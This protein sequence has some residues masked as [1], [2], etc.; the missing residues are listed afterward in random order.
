MLDN[1]NHDIS[2]ISDLGDFVTPDCEEVDSN[3][4][5]SVEVKKSS[6]RS[7]LSG[8]NLSGKLISFEGGEGS[9]KTTQISRL[10]SD[11]EKNGYDVLSLREPGGSKIAEEIREVI[12]NKGNLEMTAR[13]E[14]LCFAASRSQLMQE[15]VLPALETGK[16]VI[17]DRFVDS[18]YV[19]QGLCKS[20]GVDLVKQINDFATF[21]KEADLTI[22]IDVSPEVGFER[23][24]ANGRETNKYEMMDLGF[25]KLVRQNYQSIADKY[26]DRIVTVNGEQT[27]N[28]VYNDI[29]NVF[30]NRFRP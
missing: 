24:N 17:L 27:K 11:L 26:A 20:I 14:A 15:K 6:K 28:K 21:D 22:Y 30:N 23:I 9:G 16:V 8:L 4:E 10:V 29:I 18:S 19:Y 2:I 7:K 5:E 12:L 13:C 1:L 25:H 3:G